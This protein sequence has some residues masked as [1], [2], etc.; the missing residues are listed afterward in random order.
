MSG[1][2]PASMAAVNFGTLSA[3]V[4]CSAT[5]LMFGLRF[6]NSANSVLSAGPAGSSPKYQ[7][8]NRSWTG[9]WAVAGRVRPT[10]RTRANAGAAHATHR[11]VRRHVVMR[12]SSFH[13]T[14]GSGS[15]DRLRGRGSLERP[16]GEA[17]HQEAGR[18]QVQ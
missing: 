16:S 11:L 9:A 5:I 1:P 18:E 17:G 6:S 15:S 12:R 7:L 13:P 4:T 14:P 8:M 10:A 3:E 2:R